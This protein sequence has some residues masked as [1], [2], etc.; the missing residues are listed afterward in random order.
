MDKPNITLLVDSPNMLAANF[1]GLIA[2]TNK[3]FNHFE[4]INKKG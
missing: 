2:I 1:A 4:L 3:S